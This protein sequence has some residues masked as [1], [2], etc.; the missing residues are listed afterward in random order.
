MSEELRGW[1][2]GKREKRIT[3]FACNVLPQR[4]AG[5]EKNN[6]NDL[7]K[8]KSCAVLHSFYFYDD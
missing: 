3:R 5:A 2:E 4:H 6:Y 7:A 1:K 8:T